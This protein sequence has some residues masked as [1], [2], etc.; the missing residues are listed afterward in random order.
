MQIAAEF[1][2]ESLGK[3]GL[4]DTG[5]LAFP[6]VAGVPGI[7][8]F[9][10]S[11][12]EGEEVYVGE[13]GHL[14]RRFEHNYRYNPSGSTNIAVREWLT[15]CL[16]AGTLVDVSLAGQIRVSVDGQEIPHDLERKADRTLVEAAG[17][18]AAIASGSMLRNR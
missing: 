1:E 8:R 2:W 12:A 16:K 14:V 4:S 10:A 15:G 9:S 13:T 7:Y 17:L 11:S 6:K 3:V 18:I 5:K